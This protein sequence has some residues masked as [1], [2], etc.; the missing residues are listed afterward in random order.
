MYLDTST[1]RNNS[2][3]GGKGQQ[4]YVIN[5]FQS[6]SSNQRQPSYVHTCET[7]ETLNDYES[8]NLDHPSIINY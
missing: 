3:L 5:T 8:N 7:Q 2:A 1:D 4:Q 6:R